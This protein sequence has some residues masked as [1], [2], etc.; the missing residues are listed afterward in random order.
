MKILFSPSETKFKGGIVHKINA[1]SFLFPELFDKRMEVIAAYQRYI[2]SASNQK[3]AKLFGSNKQ[4]V[5]DYYKGKL[6]EKSIMKAVE[7]YD[8]TAFH[9]LQYP[10]LTHNNQRY[11]DGNVI[12]FSNLFGPILAGDMGLPDYKLK[13]GEKIDTFSLENFYCKYF[14]EALNEYLANE[15]VIDLRASFYE[16]FY[17]INQPYTTFKF[18]K[19]GKVISHWAKAYRGL[20]LKKFA[21]NNIQSIAEFMNLEIESLSIL[22]IKKLKL[23]TEIIYTIK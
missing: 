9:Y 4:N 16:Q 5:I 11:I 19:D 20:L 18:M 12:I 13:Q 8:G 2:D 17:K 21:Q 23:K 15:E 3:L 7:R 14:S 22:E 10:Q 1:N 6:L